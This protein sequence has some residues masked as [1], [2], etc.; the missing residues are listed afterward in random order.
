VQPLVPIDF[1]G[2]DIEIVGMQLNTYF[3][4]L[5]SR[6]NSVAGYIRENA[7]TINEAVLVS[8]KA[9]LESIIEAYNQA[10]SQIETALRNIDALPLGMVNK[11]LLFPSEQINEWK[12]HADQL[13]AVVYGLLEQ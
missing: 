8:T 2:G 12:G 13:L 4:Q 7:R 9:L 5:N 11:L 6:Y 10:Q 1:L 3:D